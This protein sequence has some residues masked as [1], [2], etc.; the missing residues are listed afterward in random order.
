MTF[1]PS[2]VWVRIP[3]PVPIWK[4]PLDGWRLV[5]KTRVT[6]RSGV[7]FL[8]LPPRTAQPARLPG[9]PAKQCVPDEGI[10]IM[11]QAVRHFRRRSSVVE[12]RVGIAPISV[13]FRAVAPGSGRPAASGSETVNLVLN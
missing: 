10:G 4:A 1:R 2:A 5:L 7:R 9:L 3:P 11:P 13:R 8:R 6:E 12:Q